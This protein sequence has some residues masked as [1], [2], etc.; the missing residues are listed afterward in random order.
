MKSLIN[1]LPSREIYYTNWPHIEG[2]EF[3]DPNFHQAGP[4]DIL[5]EAEIVRAEIQNTGNSNCSKY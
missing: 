5:L 2:I 4:I 3:A 1:R